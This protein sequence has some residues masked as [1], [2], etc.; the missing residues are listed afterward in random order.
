MKY[1][2]TGRGSS[3]NPPNR[4]EKLHIEPF[5]DDELSDYV[6]LPEEK[7]KTEFF[8]DYSKSALSKNNS[9]D[10]EFNYSLNPYKGCEHGRV[11]CYARQ[12]HE[13]LG[14]SSGVDFE[15]KIFVKQDAPLLLEKTFQSKSWKPEIIVFSGNTDCYQPIE[16]KLGITRKCLE[17]CLNHRNPVSIITKNAL[18]KRD[19]DILKE[20]AKLNLVV[21]TLSITTLKK[22]LAGIMEPRTSSPQKRIE[23]INELA[24]NDIPVGV[25]I[26]PLIPGLNDEEIPAILKEAAINGAKHAGYILLRLP[27]MVKD[28]FINWLNI[29]MPDRADK[30]LNRIKEIRGGKLNESEI[31]KR[32]SGEGEYY[33][34]I[35]SL[36]DLNCRLL[37]LNKRNLNLETSKFISKIEDQFKLF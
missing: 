5:S 31:G 8:S 19:I 21:V 24:I 28:I 14:L 2:K 1:A 20:M 15:S 32:F 25:N 36:F 23:T 4:F 11:Y 27:Y 6:D 16:R 35:S 33:N 37:K 7:I 26:A 34:S 3:I 13:Y 30:I 22:E 18:I 12:T 10:L 17:V 9:E 29:N